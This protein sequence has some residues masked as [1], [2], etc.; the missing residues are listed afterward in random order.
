MYDARNVANQLID[1]S[2]RDGN[3]LTPLQIIKLVYFCHSWMLGFHGV[4]LVTQRVEA[5]KK[6]S[7]ICRYLYS[8]SKKQLEIA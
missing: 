8:H 7:R 3:S 2:I 6:W 5:W 1:R 4:P